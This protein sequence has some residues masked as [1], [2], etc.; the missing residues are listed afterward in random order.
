LYTFTGGNDGASPNGGLILSGNTL[1]GTTLDGG[2]NGFGTLFAINADG[3]GFTT[4][5]TFTGGNDGASPNGGLILSGNTLYGTARERGASGYHGTVFSVNTDGTEFMNLY[6]FTGGS[7]GADPMAGSGLILSNN[8]L[9]G[10]TMFGGTN[11]AG[12]LFNLALPGRRLKHQIITFSQP[13]AE[14][15]VFNKIFTLMASAPGGAVTFTSSDTNVISISGD[16]ATIV[17]AG[18]A[19]IAA[20]QSGSSTYAA[21]TP[22]SHVL[23][24]GKA[25]QTISLPAIPSH[26]YGDAAFPLTAKASSSTNQTVTFASSKTNV[27]TVSGNTL[28]I[29]GAGVT[30]ITASVTAPNY[31]PATTS[32]VLTVNKADQTISFGAIPSHTYGDAAFPLTATASSSTNQTV[33]FTSSKTNVATVSGNMV[34]LV[35]AGL[36]TIT[37]SVPKSAN[38]KAAPSV[39][40]VLSVVGLPQTISFESVTL[41]LGD[42]TS[43]TFSVPTGFGKGLKFIAN[44]LSTSGLP[45]TFTSDNP[46]V[47]SI[48]SNGVGHCNAPGSANITAHQAGNYKYSK[49]TSVTTSIGVFSSN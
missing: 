12:T 20:T 2:T 44:A 21:A 13:A 23:V 10:T 11:N 37:A 33:T 14:T 40:Q 32:R 24:V 8:V 45:V 1:Y 9:Y 49:A 16:L 43:Q 22:V 25:T 3:T 17:G 36:S 26:T 48:S 5:Y 41:P 46:R 6:S 18:K 42:N 39:K 27:A 28:A 31:I 19:V 35:G 29:V 38:F 34:T 30:T 47:V 4:L 7:D 15:F